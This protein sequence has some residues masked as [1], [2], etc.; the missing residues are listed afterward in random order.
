M[1]AIETA[2]A[3]R[4]TTP[5]RLHMDRVTP[6]ERQEGR[7]M[8][9]QHNL[10]A[11]LRDISPPTIYC[12]LHGMS[13]ARKYHADRERLSMVAPWEPQETGREVAQFD[14]LPP[15]WTGSIHFKRFEP[16]GGDYGDDVCVVCEAESGTLR[17]DSLTFLAAVA[18]AAVPVSL[19]VVFVGRHTRSARPCCLRA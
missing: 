6:R 2:A 18:L 16:W 10:D 9:A 5:E 13:E 15:N 3:A 7:T 1:T 17:L 11:N 4:G 19:V 12:E 8:I 14:L